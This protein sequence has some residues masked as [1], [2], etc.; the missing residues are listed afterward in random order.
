ML[1]GVKITAFAVLTVILLY[2]ALRTY[3]AQTRAAVAGDTG[4]WIW[5]YLLG[6]VIVLIW[7]GVGYLLFKKEIDEHEKK[8]KK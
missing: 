7:A 2:A 4:G 3:F 8:N 5:Y 6:G 1:L